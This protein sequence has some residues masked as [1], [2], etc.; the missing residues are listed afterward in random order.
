MAKSSYAVV[1][2]GEALWDMLPAGKQLGGASANFAYQTAMLGDR[3]VVA[4]RLGDDASGRELLDRFRELGL[5]ADHL[6]CDPD[7]PTGTVAV[8]VDADGQPDFDI[9]EDVAWDYLE[10]SPA[11]QE[12]AEQADAVCFGSLAQRAPVSRATIRRFL[13]HTRPDCVRVCDV[14]LRQHYFS[15][16]ILADSLN[17]ARVVK[18]NDEEL[19]RVC[20]CLSLPLGDEQA[21]AARLRQ[22]YALD[23]LCVTRGARGSLAVAADAV[24]EHPGCPATVADTVGAGDAF[25]AALVH[26]Y[27]RGSSLPRLSAAANLLGAWTASQ[28]GGTPPADPA[29]LAK[30][31]G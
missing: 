23:L 12:L 19:P 28:S 20:E 24:D 1:G 21:M 4:S 3:A 11:W 17:S 10:W 6:Q 7:H 15:P 13:G 8:T 14:N 18:L 5:T 2:L 25:T 26:H 27:L 9:V 16:E 29:L 30:V 31:R 22:E